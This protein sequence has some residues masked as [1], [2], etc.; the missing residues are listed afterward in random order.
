[1][2]STLSRYEFHR[3]AESRIGNITGAVN[4][5]K[6]STGVLRQRSGPWPFL[7]V[8][9]CP[10]QCFPG[11]LKKKAEKYQCIFFL[12]LLFSLQCLAP[13][14]AMFNMEVSSL[15]LFLF[16]F[17]FRL[18]LSR[19]DSVAPRLSKLCFFFLSLIHFNNCTTF[20]AHV[21]GFFFSS[22]RGIDVTTQAS[23]PS[24]HS[25]WVPPCTQQASSFPYVC[26]DLLIHHLRC[27]GWELSVF[28][29]SP[30]AFLPPLLVFFS[31]FWINKIYLVPPTVK[32][33]QRRQC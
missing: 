31:F 25:R 20:Y 24:C 8:L 13:D 19:E 29:F 27:S 14:R 10:A 7:L 30:F 18:C 5:N 4:L 12:L 2:P 26:S 21:S 28:C 11:V 3:A 9:N 16:V 23:C 33:P 6:M 22:R 15:S 17:R 1:M 32:D